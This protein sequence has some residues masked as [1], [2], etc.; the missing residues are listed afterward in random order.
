MTQRSVTGFFDC[1]ACAACATRTRTCT[2]PTCTDVLHATRSR[3]PALEPCRAWR[4]QQATWAGGKAQAVRRVSVPCGEPRRHRKAPRDCAG[5]RQASASVHASNLDEP[6]T[7][8]A[9]RV[10]SRQVRVLQAQRPC[11]TAPKLEPAPGRA[12][13]GHRACGQLYLSG[14]SGITPLLSMSR[15]WADLG[16]DAV[17][18]F[19]RAR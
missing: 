7:P 12:A 5:T 11:R 19:I 2:N 1:P 17:V 4:C 9:P 18:Q 6:A 15:A 8:E 14:G 13:V 3:A 10:A 16:L